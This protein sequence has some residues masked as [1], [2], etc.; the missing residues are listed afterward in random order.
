MVSADLF[1]ESQA[2]D[3]WHHDVGQDEIVVGVLLQAR[4]RFFG[5]FYYGDFVATVFEQG[6]YDAAHGLFIVDDQDSFLRHG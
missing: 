1:Q 4:Q 2:I 5:T 3:A 6:C